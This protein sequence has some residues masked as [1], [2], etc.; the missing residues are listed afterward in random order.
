MAS[1]LVGWVKA[2]NPAVCG[3]TNVLSNAAMNYIHEDQ[4]AGLRVLTQPTALRHS[5]GLEVTHALIK[6][7]WNQFLFVSFVLFVAN[8]PKP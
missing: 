1:S 5:A 4:N 6:S 2:R 3:P 7:H 8:Y